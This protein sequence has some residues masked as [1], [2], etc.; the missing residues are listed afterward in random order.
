MDGKEK[1]RYICYAMT[2]NQEEALYDFLD[3]AT[4][5]FTLE[6]VTSY[7]HDADTTR[8]GRLAVQIAALINV[9]RLAFPK[10]S[11][12][13]VPRRSCFEH[14]QF[15]I[16]PSR[17]EIMQ[18]VLIP[19]HRCVPFVN[20]ILRP[21]EYAFFWEKR[22]VFWTKTKGDPEELYPYY[23]IFGEE[24]APHYIAMDNEENEYAYSDGEEPAN[25]SI[26]TLNM[27]RI[28]RET[29]FVP[30][31]AFITKV[32]D[33]K[34]GVF[35]LEKVPKDTWRESDLADWL[36]IAEEGFKESFKTLGPGMTTE[37][38][39]A[40]AYFFGGTR[41]CD[42]P[43][44]SLEEFLYEK[45]DSI[46]T[47][48]YGIETRF[49]FAGKE[50]PDCR[51][52]IDGQ[53]IADKTL[54]EELLFSK[55]IP[56]SE[57]VVQAYVRDSL[58]RRETS[59]ENVLLR[60]I[61]N[62]IARSLSLREWNTLAD[63]IAELFAEIHPNYSIFIDKHAGPIRQ[64]LV[65]LHSAVIEFV[66]SLLKD[67]MNECYL[68]QQAFIILSQ[69]QTRAA[70]LLDELSDDEEPPEMDM[71]AMDNAYLGMLD[72][73]EEIRAMIDDSLCAFRNT[74]LYLVKEGDRQ[75]GRLLQISIGGT[76]VWRRLIVPEMHTLKDMHR[77]IQK[78]FSW[79]NARSYR[80]IL[81]SNPEGEE[82]TY[83]LDTAITI[84]ELSARRLPDVNYEYGELWNVK[85]IILSPA[86]S[87]KSAV[88]VAGGKAAPPDTING[89][90]RFKKEIVALTAGTVEARQAA[91]NHLGADFNPDF[92]DI[93]QCNRALIDM[94]TDC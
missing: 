79:N 32:V 56:V 51:K 33:W 66:A 19:G 23:T 53:R 54:I 55:G 1:K 83:S 89:P 15:V 31:D 3:N 34:R 48:P 28:Y 64:N 18:G 65:E 5:P 26:S 39:I 24:Y 86:E 91:K 38:Q 76:E 40:H 6:E 63:Y 78:L 22:P 68:P 85:I 87:A 69:I 49:W 36:S 90:V 29:A 45:T 47:V 93:V 62:P 71:L 41:M 75:K 11:K 10:G 4:E 35:M 80:F 73:Y 50:I 94:N 44:Y 13:W 82:Q 42:I 21:K 92:F 59:V 16:K 57:F 67:S 72:T 60:L 9:K 27:S 20:P 70:N 46:E 74:T 7:V 81:G 61:P 12:R 8:S 25:V 52:L 30:G 14:R 43:A 37:E 58:Y 17:R 2:F 77:I 84:K 88:C